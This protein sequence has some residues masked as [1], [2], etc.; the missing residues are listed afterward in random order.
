[1]GVEELIRVWSALEGGYYGGG[2]EVVGGGL[3][4][5]LAS[6]GVERATE[7]GLIMLSRWQSRASGAPHNSPSAAIAITRPRTVIR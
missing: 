4:L 2:V 7:G 5:I 3:G 6:V 1:M